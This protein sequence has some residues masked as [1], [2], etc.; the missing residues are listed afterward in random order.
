MLE[1]DEKTLYTRSKL[2]LS[3]YRDICWSTAGRADQVREDLICY[4]G[5]QLDD[6]LI[7]LETF[8]PD[9][10]REHFEELSR[11]MKLGNILR[12]G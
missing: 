6:A 9:E 10:A 1:L 3:A 2:I 12:N 8:A 5:S 4:C 11:R 7:Y